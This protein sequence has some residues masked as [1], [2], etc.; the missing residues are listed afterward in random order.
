MGSELRG[1]RAPLRNRAPAGCRAWADCLKQHHQEVRV[2]H[3]LG[4]E[5]VQVLARFPALRRLV[6]GEV[7]NTH[8]LARLT[9]LT[10][11]HLM[12]PVW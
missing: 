11:L 12:P 7:W 1:T 4:P 10:E 5:G 6:L 9:T 8:S 3:Y 2:G